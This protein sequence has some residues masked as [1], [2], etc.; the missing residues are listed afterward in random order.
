MKKSGQSLADNYKEIATKVRTISD[1][2]SNTAQYANLVLS[3]VGSLVSNA[4][5]FT[6]STVEI[7]VS[8]IRTLQQAPRDEHPNQILE[9]Y[10]DDIETKM[11]SALN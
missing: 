9:G 5:H 4:H 3:F 2:G 8:L 1:Y 10:K 6:R 7:F 11:R